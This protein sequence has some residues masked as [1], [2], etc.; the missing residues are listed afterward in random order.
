LTN[1]SEAFLEALLAAQRNIKHAIDNKAGP[2]ATYASYEALHDAVVPVFN[3]NNI[4]VAQQSHERP[5]A[6]CIETILQFGNEVLSSGLVPVPLKGD[7]PQA[8]GSAMTYCRRYSLGL[9]AGIG[10]QS[11]D[12]AM[13]AEDAALKTSIL[14]AARSVAAAAL[15]EESRAYI[16]QARREVDPEAEDPQSA[17]ELTNPELEKILKV[18]GKRKITVEGV[19]N[20]NNE[21]DS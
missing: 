5:G 10:H 11:D 21:K 9:A 1:I 15:T 20:G 17:E 12:D 14:D 4:H 8:F 3:E 18:M 16:G 13:A 2:Y 19:E 6:V 7:G